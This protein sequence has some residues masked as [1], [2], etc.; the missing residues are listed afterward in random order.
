MITNFQLREGAYAH[1][2]QTVLTCIDTS[3]WVIVANFR[4]ICL[5][6]MQVEQPALALLS[7]ISIERLRDCRQRSMA[8]AALAH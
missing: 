2:G 7:L 6:R 5:Q 3:Q 1:V 4:E 8:A